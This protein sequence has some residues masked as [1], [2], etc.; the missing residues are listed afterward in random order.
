MC[1][2]CNN[3]M[4]VARPVLA[5]AGGGV[6]GGLGGNHHSPAHQQQRQAPGGGGG[7][8]GGSAI[9]KNPSLAAEMGKRHLDK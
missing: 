5:G 3:I 4:S 2:A 8:G 7:G 6:D 1:P 9:P